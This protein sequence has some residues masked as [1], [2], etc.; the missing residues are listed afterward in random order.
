MPRTRRAPASLGLAQP[1]LFGWPAAPCATPQKRSYTGRTRAADRAPAE[2]REAPPAV[3]V[4]GECLAILRDMPSASV[5]ALITDPPSGTGFM[6]AHW[7]TFDGKPRRDGSADRQAA[8]DAYGKGASPYGFSSARPATRAARDGFVSFMTA[9]LSEARRVIRPGGH[10]LVWALPRTSHWTGQAL[11]DAGWEI[12]DCVYHLFG[13]GFPKSHNL[14]DGR[15]SALKP[16]VE[17]WWLARAPLAEATIAANVLAHGTGALNIEACRIGSERTRTSIKDM[18]AYHGNQFGKPGAS[19]PIT[20]YRENPPGRWPANLVLSHAPEC[21]DG[22]CAPWCPVAELDSQSGYTRSPAFTGRGAGG[23]HGR[24]SKIGA[25]GRVPAP[26]DSGGASRF[27]YVA[28]PSRSEREAGTERLPRLQG[29]AYGEYAGDGRGRQTEH[30]PTGNHHPTV[31][32]VALMRHFV[33][34]ITPPGGTVLDCFAGSGTTG[35][36]ARLEGRGFV[37]VEREAE[38]AAIAEARIAAAV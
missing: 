20:G 35:V 25:Q 34:L 7:D 16:A 26:G 30:Q 2:T 27:F 28:K 22:Q 15:G 21:G 5:D 8:H 12:R 18:S 9:V 11:D 23:Q 32:P 1:D 6:G 14:G 31:K 10:A 4:R 3:L 24:Y 38:Y 33:R 29:G 37:G 36:A 17:V 13:S 19:A